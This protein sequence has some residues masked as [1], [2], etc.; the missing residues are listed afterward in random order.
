MTKIKVNPEMIPEPNTQMRFMA[1]DDLEAHFQQRQEYYRAKK[2][3]VIYLDG[4]PVIFASDDGD[5]Q[6]KPGICIKQDGVIEDTPAPVNGTDY[7]LE[8]LKSFVGGWIDIVPLNTSPA[9]VMIV[10]DEGVYKYQENVKASMVYC[11]AS[12]HAHQKIYGNVAIL[13]KEMVK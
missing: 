12:F 4:S 9:L 5:F 8:E 7:N 6:L 10:A 1:I 3:D 13:P 2:E 11:A